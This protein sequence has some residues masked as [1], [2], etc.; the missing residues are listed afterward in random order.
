MIKQRLPEYYIYNGHCN[1]LLNLKYVENIV[2]KISHSA[3]HIDVFGY[4]P[5]ELS[6]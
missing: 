4:Y 2:E 5:Y 1:E 6:M 3:L